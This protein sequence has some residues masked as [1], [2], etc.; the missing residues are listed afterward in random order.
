MKTLLGV[1]TDVAAFS[2]LAAFLGGLY[3]FDY[4]W[5]L[6]VV[7]ALVVAGILVFGRRK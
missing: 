4:R 7:G 6:I 1:L 5:L 3:L 2:A